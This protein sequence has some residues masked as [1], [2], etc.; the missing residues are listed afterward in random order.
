MELGTIGIWSMQLRGAHQ[1][2]VR[3]AAAELDALGYGA[4]WSPGLD[5][6]GAFDD[7]GA[8]LAAAPNT[9]VALG[10]LGVWG[11]R[12]GDVGRR[13]A[14]LDGTY[15]ARTLLGLGVSSPES[16]EA[17]GESWGSPV[18]TMS[19]Y[20]AELASSPHPVAR[21][22]LVLGALGPRMAR[23]AA[24]RTSGLHPFLV[25]PAYAATQREALGP[26]PLIAPHL[27][28]VFDTDPSRAR[29]I[30]RDGVG[31]FLGLPAYRANL[32]RLG[33]GDD[34]LIPG[35]SDRLIDALVAHGDLSDVERRVREHLDAGADHVALHVLTSDNQ[36]P[37]PRWR[38]LATLR[39]PTSGT[40]R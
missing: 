9:V 17:V 22:R 29:D 10:V 34:D 38:E 19:S 28:V 24:T 7:V 11:Q 33:F 12:P 23:L 16:A 15:G 5:G 26:G 21:D 39:S 2:E 1:P 8:L 25:P 32:A 6:Q 14:D 27:A 35:G 37:L 36:L 31:F 4:L 3:D 13:L 18:A 20:L 30:A 40:S